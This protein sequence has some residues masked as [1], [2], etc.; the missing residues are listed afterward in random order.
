[1]DPSKRGADGKYPA[2]YLQ[3]VYTNKTFSDAWATFKYLNTKNIVPQ[4]N[5]S[6][7]IS[8]AMG[9]TD[10]IERLADFEGYAEMIATMLVWARE[11]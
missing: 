9:K 11:K 2:D 6:G 8:P 10:D 4:F 3:R 5:V 7:P 1:M